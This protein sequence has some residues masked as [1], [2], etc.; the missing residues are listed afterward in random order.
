MA[1]DGKDMTSAEE[2]AE[3][4]YG[5]ELLSA[6]WNP[7]IALLEWSCART[8]AQTSRDKAPAVGEEDAND[9]LGRVYTSG[10]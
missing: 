4:H 7:V 6:S 1:K 5:D 10:V 2:P 9:F 3:D 8:G